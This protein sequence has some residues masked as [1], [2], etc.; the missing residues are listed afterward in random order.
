MQEA[1]LEAAVVRLSRVET[2]LERQSQEIVTVPPG[3]NPEMLSDGH[4][5]PNSSHNG[6]MPPKL[7]FVISAAL[8]STP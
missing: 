1:S 8:F 3:Q 5:K 4:M 7:L 6:E 2:E